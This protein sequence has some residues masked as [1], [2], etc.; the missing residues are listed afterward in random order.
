MSIRGASNEQD[1]RPG[2]PVDAPDDPSP[3]LNLIGGLTVEPLEPAPSD[4]AG[5]GDQTDPPVT[6]AG[7]RVS[8]WADRLRDKR[9]R[10]QER[11]RATESGPQ[12]DPPGPAHWSAESVI[13][14]DEA[15][16]AGFDLLAPVTSRRT[17]CL[18]MLGL[19]PS[20][21][22]D[23]I[24]AAY[25]ALAKQHHPD[26]WAEADQ[27]TQATHAEAMLRVNAA[28]RALREVTLG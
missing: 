6:P 20:A 26:R 8:A 16:G 24:A 13:G 11:I 22:D 18:G 9:R 3:A 15:H 10:D 12:D 7:E 17:E 2:P 25:R 1:Q 4:T 23:D 14:R 27:A 28:Y 21:T 19:D 5:P